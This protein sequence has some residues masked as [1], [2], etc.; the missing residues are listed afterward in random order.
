MRASCLLTKTSTPKLIKQTY[1]FLYLKINYECMNI[2]LDVGNTYIKAAAFEGEQLLWANIF[3]DAEAIF[4]KVKEKQPQHVFISSVRSENEF[5]GLKEHTNVLY[6]TAERKLPIEIAYK[7]PNSLGS[8]RIAA[9][10]GATVLFPQQNT[11]VFDIGTCLTHGIIDAQHTYYGGSISPGVQM[12]LKSLAHFTQKL[13]LLEF[14]EIKIEITGNS[15]T[16]SI[17]SGVL[18]GIQFEMEGFIAFYQNKYQSLNVLLTGGS[19][20]L[21]EKRL[22]EY[23]FVVPELN[24]IGLN[25]ILNY[26][27]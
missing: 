27:V 24:L 17:Y 26:N 4:I 5:Y 1:N 15:T 23:I 19:T 20:P 2:V 13:P 16:E 10:V 11:L 21:F 9:A 3:A 22:K 12:R 25:R 6:L 14:P 8:D 18:N 7:T